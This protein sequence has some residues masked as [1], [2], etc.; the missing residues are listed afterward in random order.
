MSE[1]EVR[2]I[3]AEIV[4]DNGQFK[5]LE[6][7]VHITGVV[8]GAAVEPCDVIMVANTVATELFITQRTVD[9]CAELLLLLFRDNHWLFILNH[10]K[11]RLLSF[12][13]KRKKVLHTVVTVK[14]LVFIRE[15][16]WVL[17]YEFTA[18]V[19]HAVVLIE[20]S[21]FTL[22]HINGDENT[23][24]VS[25]DDKGNAHHLLCV[26]ELAHML[27][28]L[29]EDFDGLTIESNTLVVLD[30]ILVSR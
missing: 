10:L 3:A 2:V 28:F 6:I 25:I 14:L 16:L 21:A 26:L 11:G 13:A 24:T 15:N 18:D 22:I 4:E 23:L 27:A 30:V 1:D 9:L 29:R 8:A 7:K 19:V 5:V 20:V 12:K 17:R